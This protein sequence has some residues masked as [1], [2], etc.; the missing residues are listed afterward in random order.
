MNRRKFVASAGAAGLSTLSAIESIAAPGGKPAQV[1]QQ[2]FEWHHY[3]A[4]VGSRKNRLHDYLKDAAIPAWNRLGISP[5]GVFNVMYG[6]NAPSVFVLLPHANIESVAA[7]RT[8]LTEDEVYQKAGADFLRA[9]L[10]D[11]AFVRLE[12][13]LMRAFTSMPAVAAPATD[14]PR[15]FEYRIYE[16]HS[17]AAALRKIEMFNNGEIPIFHDTGLTPVFFAETL[18]GPN[19]PNLTYMLTFKDLV[20]RD[21]A[22]DAF[23]VHPDWKKM[24]GD[25]YYKDTVSN[26][27]DFILRPAPYSQI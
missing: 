7:T 13:S 16:S 12:T 2:Y 21:Q 9:A 25:P 3:H 24:S 23:R 22:W 20:A 6:P 5:V 19:L 15:I 18:V 11:P 27:T 26:I 17:E 8:K 10:D 4:L 1:N 14:Q